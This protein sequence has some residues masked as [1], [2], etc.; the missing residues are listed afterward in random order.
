LD[1]KLAPSVI[2]KSGAGPGGGGGDGVS[3]AVYRPRTFPTKAQT[4]TGAGKPVQEPASFG[5]Q[6]S[7]QRAIDPISSGPPMSG[8][9]DEVNQM[10]TSMFGMILIE[11]RTLTAATIAEPRQQDSQNRRRVDVTPAKNAARATWLQRPADGRETLLRVGDLELDRIERRAC[12][13]DRA[14][15]L[16]PREFLLLDYLMRHAGDLVTRQALLR[17]VWHYRCVPKTNL[18]D[19][20]I[21]RLRRKLHAAGELSIIHTIRGAGFMLSMRPRSGAAAQVEE[22]R[23]CV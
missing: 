9:A 23:P 1:L 11:P 4:C 21:G 12:R 18:V 6:L 16:L 2:E 20:H 5:G 3:L 22:A 17:E 8:A 10:E 7:R 19:V 15:D 14:I 13:R